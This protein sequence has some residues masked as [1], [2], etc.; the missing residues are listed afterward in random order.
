M[1][2]RVIFAT[3]LV[4]L[5]VLL[6]F[7]APPAVIAFVAGVVAAISA[8]ELLT[9]TGLVKHLRLVA[10]T[11]ILAFLVPLWCYFGMPA[12]GAQ[13]GMLAYTALMFAE[14]LFSKGKLRIEKI[15]VCYLGGLVFP[16][17]FAALIRMIGDGSGRNVIA[18][19]F[20]LAC[21]S[22]SGAYFIG[23]QWGKHKLAP[24]ISPKKSV[25]G[26]FGGIGAAVVAM[27][28]YCLV[29]N[30]A[31]EMKVN[32]LYA[33]I[34]GVIG[35]LCGTFGDLCFSVVKR[36]V[37]IKDY[38]KLIPGHGGALDRIDSIIFV[39]ALTEVLLKLLPIVE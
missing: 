36:Q 18:I 25:E 13:I 9:G 11:I 21:M 7:L 39:S 12:F 35:A 1:K 28:A 32:Y 6:L 4:V 17:M 29:M 3:I 19:P 23:C 2:T 37:G 16:F 31:F 20:L 5:L 30:L 14:I 10:Y 33:V 24:T 22:D 26:L 38:G 27:L 8:Y 34:Y 15:A